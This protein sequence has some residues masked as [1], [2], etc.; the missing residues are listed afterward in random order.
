M[1][2]PLRAALT[3][4][5]LVAL[6]P[7]TGVPLSGQDRATRGALHTGSWAL[8]NV[9]VVP[10]TSQEVLRDAVVLVRD[11]RIEA[12]G[13]A[14]STPLP[15]G[16]LAVDG[17]GGYVVPGLSDMHAHLYSDY[18]TYGVEDDEAPAE[19]GVFL[20]NGI[21]T[22]RFMA[23]TPEQLALRERVRRGDVPG[24]QIWA[25]GPMFAAEPGDNVRVVASPADARVAVDEVVDA[26]YDF[27]KLTFGITGATYD[28]V[29]AAARGRIP[30]VGHVEPELGL[31]RAIAAG[32]QLEHLDAFFE[33]AL[34]DA[35]PMRTSVTQF[36]VYRPENWESLAYLDERKLQ[37]LVDAVVDGGAWV[38]PTLEVFNRAFGDPYTDAELMAL[39]DW[40]FIPEAMK[41]PYLRSRERYWSQPVPTETRRRYA[42][43]RGG[44]VKAI[45]DAG[46][47]IMAGG[48]TPDLLMAYGFSLHR[49]LQAMVDAGLTPYQALSTA[50]RNP[51]EYLG[52]E[53]DFGTI[54]AG[55]RADFVLL[56][57]DPLSDIGHTKDIRGVSVGGRWW[58]PDELAELLEQGRR[59]IRQEAQGEPPTPVTTRLTQIRDTY[60]SP[61]PD[62]LR[63]AFQS[64]R[65]GVSQIFVMDADGSNVVQLTHEPGGAETPAWSPD[66]SRIVYAVY[67]YG[68]G[69]DVFVMN[70][71]G[72]EQRRLTT[73]PGYDDHP[74]WSRD[75]T[76]IVFNSDRTTPDPVAPWGS[77]WHE[78]FSMDP[79]GGDVR[80]HTRCR[81]VC[82]FASLSPAG[83]RIL[84]RK[85]I[86]GDGLQWDLT[87]AER[88]SEVFVASVDGTGEVNLSRNAA[89][90]GWPTWSPR[91]DLIAFASNRAGPASVGQIHVIEVDGGRVRQ[92][93][94]GSWS[95]T[96]PAWSADGTKLYAYQSREAEGFEYGGIVVID[97]GR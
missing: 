46:G 9:H 73:H 48:D 38:V 76:R 89:F 34:S 58:A 64:N 32:Q 86:A 72:S 78:V 6:T 24:P 1:T 23:G 55:R 52:R 30:L 28:A 62:G 97:L 88:D 45:A 74:S 19:L 11:G 43:I 66:G 3:L 40:G 65:A 90:D 4:A 17:G 35:A 31:E 96:Q 18:A 13:P 63:V 5:A 83:D 49:E 71:D 93:T 39:P 57:A 14:S 67:G 54:Q 7:V 87:R 80:Q 75:G 27:V 29:V 42:E 53:H 82:T 84:Y 94:E 85:V 16:V 33:G 12:V 26:G 95:H 68:E 44:I 47:R 70:A 10:M 59:A 41:A 8:T 20:A 69:N 22:V 92:I 36:G 51:A 2:S 77:R 25:A 79:D 56:G 21:T 91:G 60:P 81:A 37:R 61:S 50:T 15:E